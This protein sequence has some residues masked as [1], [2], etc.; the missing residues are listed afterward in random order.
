M[1]GI[2][3]A[4][5]PSGS[6]PQVAA[7]AAA[8]VHRGPDGMG[9]WQ[10]DDGR[11]YLSHRR[12]AIIDLSPAG[13][14]PMTL[15][16]GRWTITYNGELYNY[17]ELRDE[18]KN[19]HGWN[20]RTS[21]D[22]E[23]LVAACATWGIERA[24]QR[25]RGMWAFG[26]WDRDE[27]C[28]WLARD[29]FGEKPLYWTQLGDTVYFASELKA[30]RTVDGFDSTINVHAL[31][32]YMRL[33]AVQGP[34]SIYQNT[35]QVAPG[36]ALRFDVGSDGGRL[37]R[38]ITYFDALEVARDA[39]S[40]PFT[41]TFPE[42]VLATEE[43]LTSSVVQQMVSDVP[44][45]AFLSGGI[46]SS[47]VVAL[48]QASGHS[49]VKTFTV[50]FAEKHMSEADEARAIATHLGTDHTE[51][52]VA[53][54][55]ALDVVPF[56]PAMYDEPFADSSQIPTHLVAHLARETVTV[57][58]SGDGGDEF[59]GGYNRYALAG[60]LW[61]RTQHV[62]LAARSFAG[63]AIRRVP[64]ARIDQIGGFA[65][66][67]GVGRGLKGGIG[68][69][70]HKFAGLLGAASKDRLY[71][72]MISQWDAGVVLGAG[73]GS[74]DLLPVG[75]AFTDQMMLSDT[76]GYLPNDI[77]TKVDRAAM[78]VSLETRVPILSED[79]YRLAWSLP[80]DYKVRSGAGKLVLRDVLARHV[81][82]QLFERPKMG[83]GIPLDQ[84]LRGPLRAWAGDL[85]SPARLR[86]QG[87]LDEP[88]ITRRWNEHLSGRRN[89]Q[90]SLWTAL[91][92]QG[93]LDEWGAGLS[94]S[95]T[96]RDGAQ[97]LRTA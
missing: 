5:G 96:S 82:R 97:Q 32:H 80:M 78:A 45:G 67:L 47:T 61:N 41:G 33:A 34:A 70:A 9:V 76:I 19:A 43:L 28:L 26:L 6:K 68:D 62:P 14:Q 31:D 2:A 7:M 48:M 72:S 75:L 85:L 49:A 73:N 79:V 55:D 69:R 86:H 29:R 38:S 36:C 64:P 90:Y 42:A 95:D 25:C 71:E 40:K 44:L 89:W 65:Q 50:G 52:V 66:S 17:R 81:P 93:W 56:L 83:F 21:S 51:I 54:Q 77:L 35:Q 22:T 92:F 39:M 37:V 94:A 74:P 84:W 15:G 13:N 57:A 58:L 12:L 16:D 88:A 59:F 1:C 53:A 91:M 24:L 87:L 30:L 3:G 8:I 63:R 4:A 11:A 46:D 27:S 18:L 60:Q 20:F 23:V 10:S